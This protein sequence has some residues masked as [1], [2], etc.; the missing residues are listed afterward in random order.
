[1]NVRDPYDMNIEDLT[2]VVRCIQA[3]LLD[4]NNHENDLESIKGIMADAGLMPASSAD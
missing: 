4:G 3:T 1:M 2:E